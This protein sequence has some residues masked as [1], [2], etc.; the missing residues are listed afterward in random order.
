VQFHTAP[1]T[2]ALAL[3]LILRARPLESM[4]YA[5]PL[6]YCAFSP[7]GYYYSFLV[8]LVLLP[9]HHGTA[10]RPRL[11]GMALLALVSAGGYALE[12]ASDDFL[13]LFHGAATLIGVYFVAW[14]A[15]EYARLRLP[16]LEPPAAAKI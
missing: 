1:W 3:P 12:I 4:M 16:G 13:P 15:L 5:V 11:L 9:W 6:V 7:A 2:V 14:L 8:V 10:D